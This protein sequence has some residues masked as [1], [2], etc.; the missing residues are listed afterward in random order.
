MTTKRPLLLYLH[1]FLGT[2][3]ELGWFNS[4]HDSYDVYE[5]PWATLL[6]GN[7][8]WTMA[9]MA[10]AINTYLET[11]KIQGTYLYGYSMGGRLAMQLIS[12][13]PDKWKGLILESAHVGFKNGIKRREQQLKWETEFNQLTRNSTKEFVKKWYDQSLFKYSKS[14]I[15]DDLYKQK[16]SYQ[17]EYIKTW[18]MQLQT[19]NQVYFIPFL[20]EWKKPILYLAGEADDKYRKLGKTIERHVKTARTIIIKEADHNV[21]VCKPQEVKKEITK[22]INNR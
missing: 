13:Y 21:H 6:Q 1:G 7:K 12:L 9:D 22:F 18:G 19:A 17:I 8:Q 4:N 3:N 14:L 5:V 20:K 15:R 11:K 16:E 2:T 10:I